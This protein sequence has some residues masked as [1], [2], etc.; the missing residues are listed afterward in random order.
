VRE[1]CLETQHNRVVRLDHVAAVFG[2]TEQVAVERIRQLVEE[3]RIAG[4]FQQDD[5][6]FVAVSPDELQAMAT[7]IQTKGSVTLSEIASICERVINQ[8]HAK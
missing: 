7:S 2:V 1:F 3:G 8:Q 4:F 6:Q 5:D